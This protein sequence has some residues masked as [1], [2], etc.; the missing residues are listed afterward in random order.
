[1]NI[2]LLLIYTGTISQYYFICAVTGMNTCEFKVVKSDWFALLHAVFYQIIMLLGDYVFLGGFELGY[3][4]LDVYD[5]DAK[6]SE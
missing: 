1:M 3:E 4:A 5:V 2:T 6:I